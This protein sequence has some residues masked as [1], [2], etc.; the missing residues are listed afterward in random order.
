MSFDVL[1]NADTTRARSL[2]MDPANWADLSEII[3]LSRVLSVDPRGIQR[4][5]MVFRGC[6]WF[7]CRT[8][9]RIE[10]VAA[11]SES[12]VVADALPHL[13]DFKF[14]RERWRILSENDKTRVQYHAELTPDF[15]I[16]PLIGPWMIKSKIRKVLT[17][18][19]HHIE[20]TAAP[21]N[22]PL[23]TD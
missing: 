19:A 15:L 10:D 8:V 9:Q 7:F 12:E 11:L 14:A 20:Q 22:T 2:M 23:D 3:R 1:L 17:D 13:S 16:P 5:Q 4:V 18:A 21:D 6:V